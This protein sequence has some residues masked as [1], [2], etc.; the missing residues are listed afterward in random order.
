MGGGEG[1]RV[2]TKCYDEMNSFV[3]YAGIAQVLMS[4]QP[5]LAT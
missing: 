1:E 4:H 3:D 2:L 5:V